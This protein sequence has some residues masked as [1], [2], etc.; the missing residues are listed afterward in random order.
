MGTDGAA[1]GRRPADRTRGHVSDG[2][3]EHPDRR[4]ATRRRGARDQLH[5]MRLQAR[6]APAQQRRPAR[7]QSL[8]RRH[9]RAGAN[10]AYGLDGTFAFFENL[11]V[12]TYWARTETDGPSRATTP[13]TARSWTTRAIDTACRSSGW[14]SA[15]TS[16]PR[17][18]SSAATTWCATTR[19]SGSAHARSRGA[20]VRKYFYQGSLEY[21]E[22]TRG[23]LESREQDASSRSSS[24]TPIG[25]RVS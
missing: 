9:R 13:A 21:I 11:S 5:V 10:R 18:A 16:T 19:A 15:T 7:H 14:R 6:P 3:A 12:N 20:L 1:R 22:N 17:S 23:R 4:R 8:G 24:R 25:C 2:A